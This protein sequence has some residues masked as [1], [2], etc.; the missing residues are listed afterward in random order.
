MYRCTPGITSPYGFFGRHPVRAANEAVVEAWYALEQAHLGAGYRPTPGA[1]TGTKRNCPA[2]IGGK[3]CAE[4]GANCSLHNYCIAIDVEYSR[5]KLA[6]TYPARHTPHDVFIRDRR[7]HVYTPEQVQIIESV[8]NLHGE[9]LFKWLGWIGDYMHWEIDVKPERVSVDWST[10]PDGVPPEKGKEKDMSDM[11]LPVL[12]YGDGLKSHA[13]GD[14]T[15]LKVEVA[16]LQ[17]A[18]RQH[19][20]SEQGTSHDLV[21]NVDGS[22]WDGTLSV[23]KRFQAAKNLTVDGIV[24]EKTWGALLA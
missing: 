15:F 3:K 5:N 12:R 7:L 19:G 4:N 18:M 8:K 17:A 21:C 11:R 2:G 10:V 22:F 1:V 14:R 23:V 24:G 13:Y 16:M 20:Y 6:P 9:P